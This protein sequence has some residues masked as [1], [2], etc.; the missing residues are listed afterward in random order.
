MNVINT[1]IR[2]ELDFINAIDRKKFSQLNPAFQDLIFTLFPEVKNY[3]VI[4]AFKYGRYAKTD[5][6][7]MVHGKRKGLSIK[8][9]YKN[10]VH[11]E[12]ISKFQKYLEIHNIDK[13]ILDE[14]KR[15]LYADGTNDNTGINRLSNAEY[16]DMYED[17]VNKINQELNLLKQELTHRF[18]IETDVKYCVKVDAIVH[19]DVNDFIWV[20]TEEVEKYLFETKHVSKSLH[21]GKL[22]IQS[23][24]K[25]IKRNPEY[26]K[27]REYIQVKWFSL[28]DDMICI[29]S[30]RCSLMDSQCNPFKPD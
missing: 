1:G 11:I 23:W 15:Y 17:K 26:E 8:S 29:M 6:V 28:Y 20:T 27:R 16:I 18:L 5:I 21:V 25:N 12:P 4:R 19:G 10:S 14:L 13:N 2:N 9:G 30:K 7:L 3:D 24:D 22:Y